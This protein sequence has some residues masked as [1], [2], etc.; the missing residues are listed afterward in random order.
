MLKQHGIINVRP[1]IG[2]LDAW[3]AAGHETEDLTHEASPGNSSS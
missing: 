3:I 1:L 2:G